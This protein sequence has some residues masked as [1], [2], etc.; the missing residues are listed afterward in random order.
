[1]AQKTYPLAGAQKLHERW[2]RRYHTQQVAGIST[3]AALRAPLDFGLLKHCI[4][5]EIQRA[6]CLRLRFTM[7][8]NGERRQYLAE[9]D[10]RD[11]PLENFQNRTW[12]EVNGI[13]QQRAYQTF[14]GDDIP[15]MEFTMLQ[16]PEGYNG[17][18]LHIDHRLADSCC[19]TVLIND[20]MQ[21]YCHFRFGSEEP[22]PLADFEKQ[23]QKDLEKSSGGK[24][25][26]KDRAFWK[27]IL[28]QYGEPLYSD[29]RGPK[30]LQE[31]RTRRG[32]KKLRA[33][34]IEKDNLMVRVRDYQLD[35]QASR[36]LF[37][38][39][40]NHGISFNN[41]LLLGLRTYLS[42]TGGGQ[43]DISIQNF[44]SR[45]STHSE[46]TSGGSRTVCF[47]CRTVLSPDTEFLDAAFEVQNFQNHVYLH[48]NYDPTVLEDEIKSRY[49]TPEDTEYE[50]V[51]LTYQPLP[52]KIENEHLKG[53]P[54]KS[55][56][57]A[58]GAATKKLYLTVSHTPDGG[59]N[60]SF[61]YQ[62]AV[63]CEKDMELCYYYLMKILF[64]GIAEPDIT[65]GQMISEL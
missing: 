10:S 52:V 22:A 12:D 42:K 25:L 31:T 1:M 7:D 16:L 15:E 2:I 62:E 65:L 46:W 11:I 14:D 35:P 47:P 44:I 9:N 33:A 50:S 21:L 64:R 6:G 41:L 51:Y 3:L 28:D 29:I 39:C 63:Y 20:L 53:I 4:Q 13:L 32:D 19:L 43:E 40:L 57:Y 23:L 36:N 56:W 24:R 17:F 58:N 5:L 38:F 37:D 54:V 59:L 8:E 26:E 61:H 55:V 27:G 34:E 30:V 49:H 60:F 18:F 45:R 48:S